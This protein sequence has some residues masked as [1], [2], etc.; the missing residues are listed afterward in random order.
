MIFIKMKD[1]PLIKNNHTLIY[2]MYPDFNY[3]ACLKLDAAIS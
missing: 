2:L 3:K 1:P